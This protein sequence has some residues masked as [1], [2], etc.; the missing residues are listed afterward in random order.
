VQGGE[1][2]ERAG[3]AEWGDKTGSEWRGP[4]VSLNFLR[5]AYDVITHALTS[6]LFTDR[7][8]VATAVV[9]RRHRQT[10][11]QTE[12]E[13]E[14]VK[15]AWS[16]SSIMLMRC[17]HTVRRQFI[18]RS[19][20]ACNDDLSRHGSCDRRTYLTP[21]SRRT[22]APYLDPADARPRVAACFANHHHRLADES[23]VYWWRSHDEIRQIYSQPYT[24]I[25]H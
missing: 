17:T 11:R 13:R 10:D 2:E 5:T 7:I 6:F 23:L 8:F 25:Q 19:H 18:A 16:K 20:D 24:D 9:R 3:K 15:L 12:S 22:K 21:A 14:R 4:C 1:G